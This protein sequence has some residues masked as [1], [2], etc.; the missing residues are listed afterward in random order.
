MWAALLANGVLALIFLVFPYFRG[1]VRAREAR[2]RFADFASCLF[3]GRP[4]PG[5]GLTLPPGDRLRFAEQW[6]LGPASWPGKCEGELEAVSPPP[7]LLLFPKVKAAEERLARDVS[8]LRDRIA[9]ATSRDLVVPVEPLEG[10]ASVVGSLVLYAREAGASDD[11]EELAVRWTSAPRLVEPIRLPMALKGEA[12]LELEALRDGA[13]AFAVDA[14]GISFVEVGGGA[15]RQQRIRRPKLVRALV[16]ATPVPWLIHRTSEERCRLDPHRCARKTAGLSP[17]PLEGRHAL[18]PRW[19]GGHPIVESG[20]RF[21]GE[22]E[23]AMLARLPDGGV[24]ARVFPVPDAPS[25]APTAPIRS[26]ALEGYGEGHPAV[27]LSDRVLFSATE[28]GVVTLRSRS[29][30]DAREASTRIAALDGSAGPLALAACEREDSRWVAVVDAGQPRLFHERGADSW[31]ELPIPNRPRSA[32]G[33]L[34]LLCD[35]E[36]GELLHLEGGTSL[37]SILCDRASCQE[38]LLAEKVVDFDAARAK[39]RTVVA[40]VTE[41]GAVPVR[42]LAYRTPAKTERPTPAPCWSDGTGF[43]GPPRLAAFGGRIAIGV[44]EGGDLLLLETNDGG[45]TFRP[46]RGLLDP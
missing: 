8:A 1:G 34:R 30:V 7:A 42:L 18:P 17:L 6:L 20:L 28:E 40:Y 35:D 37:H 27:L 22:E 46:H 32:L 16:P 4:E 33:A 14:S 39:G 44:R 29:L 38:A 26:I 19:L 24:E 41:P 10:L 15:V 9:N 31:Q 25:E 45:R 5:G 11:L 36:R 3:E 23:I 43:C 2:A 12:A 21:R 13:R